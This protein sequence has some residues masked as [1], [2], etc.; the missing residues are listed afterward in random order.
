L[1]QRRTPFGDDVWE[2]YDLSKDP[3]EINDLAAVS[4]ERVAELTEAWDRAAWENQV[5]PLDERVGLNQIRPEH[6]REP[7]RVTLLPSMPRFRG[8]QQL[9][10]RRSFVL[11]VDVT[12][13]EGDA[14]VL[15][16]YGG[17]A[18]GFVLYVEDGAVHV[19]YNVYGRYLELSGGQM[20]VARQVVRLAG[21]AAAGGIL[22]LTLSI[23]DTEIASGRDWPM[24]SGQGGSSGID[25]GLNRCSPVDW[26]LWQRHGVFRYSGVLHRA[27]L[28]PGAPAPDR[29]PEYFAQLQ[30]EAMA[31]Q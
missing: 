9:M 26:R 15:V 31:L 16:A 28:E 22:T 17:Q 30:R 10:T 20:R 21:V 19:T 25:V 4:P 29:G 23:D 13:A 5:Y 11:D 1:H 18:C 7:R 8:A 24:L 3:T 12:W 14:G 2:F 27:V 6:E